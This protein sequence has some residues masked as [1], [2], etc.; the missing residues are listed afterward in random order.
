V[1]GGLRLRA[2]TED[3][4][5]ALVAACQDPEI[6]RWTTVPSPYGRTEARQLL[7]FSISAWASD[8]AAAFAVTDDRDGRLLGAMTLAF[9]WRR[10]SAEA[11]YWVAAE[12]RGRG[13]C[14]R[15]LHL[16]CRWAFEHTEVRRAFLEVIVGNEA[17]ERAAIAAGFT[18]EG[19][20]RES[21]THPSHGGRVDTVLYARLAGDPVPSL[22]TLAP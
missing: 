9:H 15:A 7:E 18:R 13:I 5:P 4:V 20:L 8:R 3:D 16:A 6:S 17:S 19:R 11:G 2:W 12:A 22:G 10:Q 14:R 21:M 1:G